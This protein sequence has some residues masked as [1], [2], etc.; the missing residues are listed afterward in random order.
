L[1]TSKNRYHR[2]MITC[3]HRVDLDGNPA[4]AVTDEAKAH[5][6]KQLEIRAA[7]IFQR[8]IAKQARV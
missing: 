8:R 6:L 4:E 2:A 5:A 3:E 1:Y 7:E